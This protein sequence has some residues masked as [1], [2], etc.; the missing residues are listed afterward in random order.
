MF[1]TDCAICVAKENYTVVYQERL[2]LE[3]IGADVFSARR[4]VSKKSHYRIVRCSSCGLLRSNPILEE[5]ELE[6][7]Y[8]E[9]RFTYEGEIENLKKTYGHYLRKLEKYGVQKERILEIGCGNGFFLEEALVQGYKEVYGVE[10]SADA[11]SKAAL[12]I[13][14]HI[15]QAIF[16]EDLF[17]DNFFDVVCLF[18]TLDHLVNPAEVLS[19][20]FKNLKKGGFIL[21]LNHNEGAVSARI[22]G[23]SSPIIDVEHT[24]LYNLKTISSLFEKT[25]FFVTESGS[26]RNQLSLLYLN[27]LLPLPVFLKSLSE[28]ILRSAKLGNFSLRLPIGNLY[29]IAKK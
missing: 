23:E 19:A 13:R 24:Y 21:A 17:P 4:A 10:P 18:Q 20:C 5:E 26:A 14:P 2:N 25:G 28:K 11:I 8:R 12:R 22:I 3:K 6:K 7:L 15:R 29:I 9:S 27:S 1:N 16:K